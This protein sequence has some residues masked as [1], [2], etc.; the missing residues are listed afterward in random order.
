MGNRGSSIFLEGSTFDQLLLGLK[1][2]H[3]KNL[4]HM[5]KGDGHNNKLILQPS[6]V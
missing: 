1:V 2:I 3:T 6:S 4:R 5:E